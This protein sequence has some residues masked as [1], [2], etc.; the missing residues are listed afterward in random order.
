MQ[1]MYTLENARMR[2]FAEKNDGFF[3]FDRMTFKLGVKNATA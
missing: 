3:L 1:R 2:K